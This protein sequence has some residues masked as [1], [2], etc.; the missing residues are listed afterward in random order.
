MKS[1]Q[2]SALPKCWT[3][4]PFDTNDDGKIDKEEFL[5]FTRLEQSD[6]KAWLRGRLAAI[7]E[8]SLVIR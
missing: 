3:L 6:L 5:S 2:S 8:A 7:K 1:L 4:G